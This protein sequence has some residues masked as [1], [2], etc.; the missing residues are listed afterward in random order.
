MQ[1]THITYNKEDQAIILPHLS[2]V[3]TSLTTKQQEQ[4]I[5]EQQDECR[6]EVKVILAC[7]HETAIDVP[8]RW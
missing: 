4:N 8:S 6:E 3:R 5:A 7:T 1:Y 2:L